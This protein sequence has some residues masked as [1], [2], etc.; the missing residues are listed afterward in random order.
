MTSHSVGEF[1]EKKAAEY[2]SISAQNKGWKLGRSFIQSGNI[3]K[4]IVGF[5]IG[6]V[7]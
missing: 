3:I 5:P 6:N 1:P 2:Y 4:N 7:Q